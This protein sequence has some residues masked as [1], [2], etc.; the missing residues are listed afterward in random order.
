M[1]ISL[2]SPAV[3]DRLREAA[4]TIERLRDELDR[5]RQRRSEPLAV[6]GMALRM[7]GG[8]ETP[9]A[10]WGMLE[11]GVDAVGPF[12]AERGD[13]AAIHHPD[14]D[15]PGTAYVT[16]GAFLDSIDGFD[17]AVFGISPREAVGM[18]PQQRIALELAWEALERAGYPPDSLVDSATGVFVGVSTTDY[19]RMRQELGDPD[20]VDHYQ[21]L[22]EPSFVAGRISHVLGLQG[23]SQVIDTTCSSSLVA[24]DA[25]ARALRDRRCDLALAGGVNLMLSP[26]GFLLMSKF[27][28]LAPDGRCKTFDEAADGYV[29]GEGAGLVAL[30]RLE[31]ALAAGD[32]IRGIVLG[33][34]VNHDGASSGMTVPNG[35]SQERVL[36]AAL[37]DGGIDPASVDYVEAHGTGT[38]LGDPIELRAL[39]AV[40]GACRRA[41]DLL[42]VGSVKTNVGHLEP[43]AGIAGVAKALLALEHERIP[44]HLHLERASTRI[45]WSSMH[46]EV[47]A[48][49][50]PWPAREGPRRAAVSSFGASGTNAHAV[51]E[52]APAAPP[53]RG[54]ADG[55]PEAILVSART[56]AAL[57]ALASRY[58]GH[59]R[60]GAALADVAFTT[61]VGRARLGEGAVVVAADRDEAIE[62][63]DALAAGGPDAPRRIRRR[64]ARHQ[65][66]AWL[67]PGQGAQTLGMAAGLRAIPAF[68]RPLSEA[69]EHL[70]DIDGR[71][72]ADIVWGGDD[73]AAVNDTGV[74][75]PALF[76]VSYALG[77][78]LLELG[79]RRPAALLGHSVGE[80]AAACLGGALDLPDA[81]R[82]VSA[83]GRLMSALPAGGAMVALGCTEEALRAAIEPGDVVAV[84]AVNGPR[85]V[86]ASGAE[87]DV[88]RAVARLEA[89]GVRAQPLRVSH[90]FHSP[91]VEPVLDDLAAVVDSVTLRAPAIPIVS[92]VTG[93]WWDERSLTAGYWTSHAASAV[94]FGDGV[95]LLAAE[96]LR[97]FVELG[98]HPVLLPMARR[99]VED[100]DVAWL[101]TL[102]R[103]TDDLAALQEALGQLDLDGDR[104]DWRGLHAG[105]AV[106]RV[107]LPTYPWERERYWFRERTSRR[108]DTPAIV[109]LGRRVPG[110][111]DVFEEELPGAPEATL[112]AVV[113]RALRGARAAGIAW[114]QLGPAHAAAPVGPGAAGPWIVQTAVR[115]QDGGAV[116]TLSGATPQQRD[117]GAPWTP[118]GSVALQGPGSGG[119][120]G[121]WAR[122][123]AV[124]GADLRS[125][126]SATC[127]DPAAVTGCE[128]GPR[129]VVLTDAR[130]TAIGE[131]T[132][133]VREPHAARQTPWYPVPDIVLEL[134]WDDAAG[135]GELPGSVRL[136]GGDDR[137]AAAVD[138]ALLERGITTVRTPAPPEPQDVQPGELVV[139]LAPADAPCGADLDYA[140]LRPSGLDHEL[141]LCR[142]VAALDERGDGA[143]VAVLTRGAAATP[144]QAVHAPLGATLHGLGRVL[145]LEHPV[146]WG[147]VVD[148]DPCGED[149]AATIVAALAA[150][151]R[152]DEQAVR[153]TR[154]LAAR[155]TGRGDRPLPA[156]PAR[157]HR[158]GTVLVTGGLGAIGARLCRRLARAGTERL[159]LLARSPLPDES[160]SDIAADDPR[161]GRIDTVRAIRALGAQVEV[162]AVDVTDADAVRTLVERLCADETL[163]LRGVVHAAGVSGP[164]FARDVTPEAYAAVWAPKVEGAWALHEA[165][166]DA[167]IDLFV[168]F[169]SVAASWGSQHLASYSA[170]NAFLDALAYQRRADG[171]PGLTVAWGTWALDSALFGADVL[172]FMESIGLRQLAADQCLDLLLRLHASGATG[173]M[174]CAADWATYRPVMEARRPRPRLSRIHATEADVAEGDEEL[175]RSLAAAAPGDRAALLVATVR[176]AV[177]AVLELDPE[178]VDADGDVFAL[179]IDSLMVMEIVA[180]LR[181][182][183][184][185][186]LR[187]S[188]LFERSSARAWAKLL[189][190]RVGGDVAPAPEREARWE[191]P[192]EL[193]AD[194]V[195]AEDILPGPAAGA[196]AGALTDVVLTGATGFVGAFVLRDLLASGARCVRC[197]V[198]AESARAGWERIA[199]NAATYLDL[200][201]DAAERVEPVCGDLA[202]PQLGL[203]SPEALVAGAG[204][205]LHAGAHVNFVHPYERVRDANVAGTQ[206]LLRI[207]ARAG[208][209][210]HHVSTYGIWGMP[211][212]GRDI[213][214]EDDDIATAGRLVTGY[215]QSKWAA[216]RLVRDAADRGVA[217]N[218]YRLGR[219]LGDATTGAAL[220]SHFTLGVVKGCLQLGAAPALDLDVEMTPV[221][222][223]SAALV[224]LAATQPVDG[225][226][227]HLV[228]G[229]HMAF[230]ELV[231]HLRARGWPLATLAPQDWFDRLEEALAGGE[232]NVLH[233]VMETVRE[234]V[235]G[236]ERAIVY[237][238]ARTQAALDGSGI[239]CPPLDARLLDTYLDRLLADGFLPEPA[240]AGIGSAS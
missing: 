206:E 55:R 145:A 114:G 43:A 209:P 90:A 200:P 12:P 165:T 29:R 216:E 202:Q 196:P 14:P 225:A 191:Q 168:C 185:V 142:R 28:A 115:A 10:F 103:G 41:D 150:L 162:E 75:Q 20:D 194:A 158:P 69:L 193:A 57:A 141:A 163:P 86:V 210:L 181:G 134:D 122:L 214:R 229:R 175:L 11:D 39:E 42:L 94:R 155:V 160:S 204:A 164:Q 195:L 106:R 167:D 186:E 104:L 222:Y 207:C 176:R 147:G 174:V 61:Q 127:S 123:V 231:E 170:S 172:E 234:L 44:P 17:P 80:F 139:L 149:D 156:V 22:G 24:L 128:D 124:A 118:H 236:G 226:T 52:A 125:F 84:A 65:R 177:G 102:R 71:P 64:A 16:R 192:S 151:D 233:T 30:K 45:P 208:V 56:P 54:P 19:V 99:V 27:R 89:Q 77:S 157:L 203:E 180:K 74:A 34:A 47:P 232:A 166:R 92:N 3:A 51:L 136:C 25:A 138:A 129:G 91:L 154:R 227:F 182:A 53:S 213:V 97:T 35:A 171:L 15:H 223:V 221:D 95:A 140:D 76:A 5:T 101:A 239:A 219:V 87:A 50:R 218:C 32:D 111:A 109:G 81:A 126:Q 59:L 63:L 68:E 119:D 187:P 26:Y 67:L 173:A 197:L 79:A 144:G 78:M 62:R 205:V 133:P 161:R 82:L 224:R 117:A 46:V 6:V 93:T 31:D 7:P 96:G 9:A 116:V 83:R 198:R 135:E 217:V 188:E 228:S 108:P 60:T 212:D 230:A 58:A 211:L 153:G 37:A 184:A 238:D 38:S 130:Q 190:E 235:V 201:P 72:L 48:S 113:E 121:A 131:V 112:S 88:R 152:E 21:L 199:A 73:P 85:D 110:A 237:D 169:S 107:E 215:V 18:D 40:Y 2:D 13:A 132:A 179:G 33:S 178:R 148:L 143:R 70:D 146:A 1:T 159:V 8:A 189:A 137:L 66:A 4:R 98:A 183:L 220:T 120:A 49:G 36:R 105:R 100:D 23:P 240:G